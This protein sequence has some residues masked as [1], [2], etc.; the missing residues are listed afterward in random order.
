MIE[1][2]AKDSTKVTIT[3]SSKYEIGANGFI[4]DLFQNYTVTS[5]R[6]ECR[7]ELRFPSKTIRDT[8][9]LTLKCFYTKK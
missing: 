9:V 6:S 2:S 4:R 5:S 1:V 8:F 7:M 3:F